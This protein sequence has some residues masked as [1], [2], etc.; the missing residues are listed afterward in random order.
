[1]VS[2]KARS[3]RRASRISS[4]PCGPRWRRS[5]NRKYCRESSRIRPRARPSPRPKPAQ[6]EELR[7]MLDQR[8]EEGERI[9]QD[10][11][12]AFDELEE[13]PGRKRNV[14]AEGLINNAREHAQE[15]AAGPARDAVLIDGVQKTEHYCIAA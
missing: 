12:A 6:S 9:L 4:R 2:R 10:L 5:K 15:I 8:L 7:E 11:D 3:I 1:M 14:A 13:S